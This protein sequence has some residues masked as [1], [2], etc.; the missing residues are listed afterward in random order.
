[1]P[2]SKLIKQN[3]MFGFIYKMYFNSTFGMFFDKEIYSPRTYLPLLRPR[4]HK[5]SPREKPL[6]FYHSRLNQQE[7]VS[8]LSG[9]WV[10]L[11]VEPW[12]LAVLDSGNERCVTGLSLL[13]KPKQTISKW[14]LLTTSFDVYQSCAY[15]DTNGPYVMAFIPKNSVDRKYIFGIWRMITVTWSIRK[16][17]VCHQNKD[18]LHKLIWKNPNCKN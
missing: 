3:N 11:H 13:Q 10:L 9:Q 17:A 1:M 2:V 14:R 8:V 12:R 15:K 18:C 4:H 16:R 5:I 6:C 7:Q